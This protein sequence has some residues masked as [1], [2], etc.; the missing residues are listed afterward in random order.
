MARKENRVRCCYLQCK[1]VIVDEVFNGAALCDADG[2]VVCGKN[3]AKRK[4]IR[5][6][7]VYSHVAI[8]V[9]RFQRNVRDLFTVEMTRHGLARGHHRQSFRR[10]RWTRLLH[11]RGAQVGMSEDQRALLGEIG[12]VLVVVE[13]RVG[14]D[15]NSHWLVRDLA[16]RRQDPG[17]EHGKV[18]IDQK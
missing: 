7:E 4:H 3:I 11:Q 17:I 6:A 1:I 5:S 2:G 13:M 8:R 18:I 16:E 12:I 14:V 10:N 9:R 15:N